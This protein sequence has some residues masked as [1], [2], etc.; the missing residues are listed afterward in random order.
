[1]DMAYLIEYESRKRKLIKEYEEYIKSKE[2]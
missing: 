1:M 2:R